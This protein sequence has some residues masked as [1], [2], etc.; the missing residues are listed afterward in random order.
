[1]DKT[2]LTVSQPGSL[3]DADLFKLPVG[4]KILSVSGELN[5][6]D[7]ELLRKWI[8]SDEV[9]S[10]LETVDL[11]SVSGMTYIPSQMF[12]RCP[13][14]REVYLPDITVKIGS[15]AFAYSPQLAFVDTNRI[16]DIDTFDSFA[17]CEN[18]PG[19]EFS[20]TVTVGSFTFRK[21]VF[22]GNVSFPKLQV[23]SPYVFYDTVIHGDVCL[24]GVT[25]CKEDAFFGAAVSGRIDL[26]NCHILKYGILNDLRSLNMLSLTTAK[27]IT[28]SPH[29]FTERA[30][31]EKIILQ[32]H[33]NKMPEVRHR[34][35]GGTVWKEICFISESQ[36]V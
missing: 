31:T 8:Q 10:Q 34:E 12:F 6:A 22:T 17:Y 1:M 35:W 24:P 4:N 26:P 13:Q 36:S 32:L 2:K 30:S 16:T 19:S 23:L 21:T 5:N 20:D 18:L 7:M 14:L 25:C 3:T 15:Q 33:E 9:K 11:R 29:T 28:L 27:K